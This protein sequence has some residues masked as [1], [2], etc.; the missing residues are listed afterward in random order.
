M[1][2]KF[3]VSILL[4]LIKPILIPTNMSTIGNIKIYTKESEDG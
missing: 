4:G 2:L 1:N 3:L